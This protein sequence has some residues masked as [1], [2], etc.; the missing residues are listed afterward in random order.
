MADFGCSNEKL[1]ELYK[2]LQ[3]TKSIQFQ[4]RVWNIFELMQP[5]L[6]KNFSCIKRKRSVLWKTF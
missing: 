3:G 1:A 6:F 2:E 4:F 5:K